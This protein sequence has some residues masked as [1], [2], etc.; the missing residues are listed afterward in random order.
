MEWLMF[1]INFCFS[2]KR[3]IILRMVAYAR[4]C[5]SIFLLWLMLLMLLIDG[6]FLECTFSLA[7][8]SERQ[9]ED[10]L[11]THQT[12]LKINGDFIRHAYI[13]IAIFLGLNI[14]TLII[15]FGFKHMADVW[16]RWV[17]YYSMK[18]ILFENITIVF[19]PT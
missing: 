1:H 6:N 19:A 17:Y 8:N 15:H 10:K 2:Q 3:T 13:I 7:K 9:L 18:I 12:F 14:C 4:K 11:D 5:L 16:P